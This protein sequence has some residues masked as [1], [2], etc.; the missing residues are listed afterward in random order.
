MEDRA[1]VTE[2]ASTALESHT[3]TT[4]E[5][6]GASRD[7]AHA[8]EPIT[9]RQLEMLRQR[10]SR[11]AERMPR[12]EDAEQSL[13]W[14]HQGRDY[15][16][17]FSRM[18]AA[19]DTGIERVRVRVS[20][21]ENGTRYSTELEMKRLAFSNFAQFVSRWNPQV[22]IHDDELDGRFHCNSAFNLA[23]SRDAIPRFHG[24]VTTAARTVNIFDQ[25]RT[26]A[27][28]DEV[29]LGGLQTGVRT[30]AL[31]SRVVAFANQPA[32]DADRVQVFAN[33]TRISF[34]ADGSYE[35]QALAGG[36]E[37]MRAEFPGGS[38]YLIAEKNAALHLSGTVN[39]K[40]LVYSPERIVVEG[41]L[42]YAD[43][44][45]V[46][47]A[48]DDYLGLV[49]DRFVEVAEPEV[50][51]PGDLVIQ[52]A[53]YAKKR[54]LVRGFRHRSG[55]ELVIFGSLTT[56]SLSATEPRFATRI[57]F[58]PRLEN[59]RPP[60]FPMT[61]RYEV[62]AWDRIWQLSEPDTPS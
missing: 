5:A 52:A 31:P 21:D 14:R 49:C 3:Q 6:P 28:R 33:D 12:I 36:S 42:V 10:L 62:A 26:Y 8:T 44:P 37:P 13:R 22:N 30:V 23:Y 46:H 43:D 50:T 24:K 58:D 51:G 38:G 48:A 1:A 9:G 18:P 2:A 29:F 40:I 17:S 32:I 4:V 56:D 59:L 20:V 55:A 61:D 41:D 11:W 57:R 15:E 54:F 27:S 47:P 53:I 7:A 16:A 39:G 34:A 60:R 35:W 25:D 45:Q 19:D